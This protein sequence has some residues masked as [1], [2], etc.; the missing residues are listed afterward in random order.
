MSPPPVGLSA[1]ISRSAHRCG[2]GVPRLPSAAA[3]NPSPGAAVIAAAVLA[4]GVAL[5]WSGGAHLAA[6]PLAALAAALCALAWTRRAR[7]ARLDVVLA[8][9]AFG[10]LGMMAG[11]WVS[12]GLH[13]PMHGMG[14]A[15]DSAAPAAWS[16]ATGVMLLACAAGCRWSCAPLCRGGWMRRVL[17]HLVAS[18]GMV[19][20]MAAAGARV[21]PAFAPFAGAAAGMHLAML[22]GM[23]GG[24]AATLPFAALLDRVER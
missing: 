18:A 12:G 13:A 11:S 17:A 10:G 20:G 21:A 14:T 2:L 23:T 5:V 8:T 7:F 22:L 16:A 9:V 4:Q 19:G 15:H 1:D 6:L 24:I 3:R